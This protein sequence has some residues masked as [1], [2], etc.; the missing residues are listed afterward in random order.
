MEYTIISKV[1]I[2]DGVL[3]KTP[4][5]YTLSHDDAINLTGYCGCWESWVEDNKSGLEDGSTLITDLF[6]S[7]PVCH[8]LGW[9]ADCI[10]GFEINLLTTL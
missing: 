4:I 10:E 2:I 7:H 3:V 8:E 5:G 1:E 6:D 9:V